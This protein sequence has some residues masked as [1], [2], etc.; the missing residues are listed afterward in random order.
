MYLRRIGDLEELVSNER[1]LHGDN[2]KLMSTHFVEV[3]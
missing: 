3:L 1:Q 2:P